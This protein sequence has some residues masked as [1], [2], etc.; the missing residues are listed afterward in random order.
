MTFNINLTFMTKSI[1]LLSFFTLI[2]TSISAQCVFNASRNRWELPD[3]S[4]CES[5]INTAAP[6]LRITPDARSG[7]LGDASVAIT[8]DA[9]AING[10]IGRVAFAE[11]LF[12]ISATYSPWLSNL[13]LNDIYLA[14]LA[15][16]YKLDDI[17]GLAASLR[18]FSYGDV[19]FTDENN[20][21]TG[22]ARPNEFAI[23]L[24]YSR[25]LSEAFSLGVTGKFIYS[26][27]AGGQMVGGNTVR[28]GYSGAVDLGLYYDKEVGSAG[29]GNLSWGLVFSNIGSKIRYTDNAD[30]P[31]DFLPMNL[32]VGINYTMH[33]DDYN[34]ISFIGELNKLLVP[35]PNPNDSLQEYRNYGI[36]KAI[37]SSF[38]D[39]PN[40]FSEELREINPSIGIEYSYDDQFAIRAGYF[41]ED[42]NKG[43][44]QYFTTGIGFRYNIMTINMSYLIATQSTLNASNPLDRTL[45]FSL[46]LNMDSE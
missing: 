44:R 18:Y 21:P 1:L 38:T 19:D 2:V 16:Y 22:S 28:P 24:G 13:G 37:F 23:D 6:F 4:L 9:N 25:K 35:T 45:R 11:D 7:A 40:G 10:N 26:N 42:R 39:A 30:N 27:L 17:Q 46:L 31:G 20:Q 43:N 34:D 32:G 29:A 41:Y 33:I 3:G 8:P 15:G 36:F 12:G 14:Y 5:S